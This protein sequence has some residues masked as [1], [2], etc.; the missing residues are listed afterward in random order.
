MELDIGHANL[1]TPYNTTEEILAAYGS[2]P[3]HVHLHGSKGGMP[4]CIY[5]W[6]GNSGFG[7]TGARAAVVLL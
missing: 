1:L 4:I 6:G 5:R 7:T 3:R 2:R